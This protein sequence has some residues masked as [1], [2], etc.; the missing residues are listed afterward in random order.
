MKAIGWSSAFGFALVLAFVSFTACNRKSGQSAEPKATAYGAALAE[1]SGGKQIASAGGT[2]GEAVVVQVNDAQGTAVPG[3]PVWFQGPSGVSFTPASGMTD[4]SGQFS[5]AV[6][7]GGMA[8]RYQ[9]AART[10][11][12]SG[13]VIETRLEEIALD[14]QQT[15][16]R[17][18]NQQYCSRCHDPEST[19]ERVSNIDNLNT[20]PH[21]FNEGETL[22]KLSDQDLAAII[23]HGGPALGKSAEMPPWGYT[24]SASDIQ[25]L[26]S[27]I[28]A[29]S[30][31]PYKKVGVIYAKN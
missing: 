21:P 9:I 25:A 19:A 31:P 18:L 5:S 26:I 7:L 22:N 23:G 2:L 8:G 13:K 1:V 28:R 14:Y 15:L 29:V 4:S 16:G 17:Q 3:A 24:L 6:T 10:R 11:D 20:K 12:S 30:D 27:Y